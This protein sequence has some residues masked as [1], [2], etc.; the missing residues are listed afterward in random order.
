MNTNAYRMAKTHIKILRKLNLTVYM[1]SLVFLF[2]V[3]IVLYTL[4]FSTYA[5]VHDY[6]HNLRHGLMLIPCH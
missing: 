2:I 4:L 5:P 1:K 6:F 3:G